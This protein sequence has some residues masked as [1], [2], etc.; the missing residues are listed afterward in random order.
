MMASSD[1]P[2]VPT[3]ISTTP[4]SQADALSDAELS[5]HDTSIVSMLPLNSAKIVPLHA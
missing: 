3:N 5:N 1:Q 2:E 4:P